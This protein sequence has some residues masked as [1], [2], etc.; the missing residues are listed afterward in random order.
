MFTGEPTASRDVVALRSMNT[1][2]PLFE[3]SISSKHL[4]LRVTRIL[5][6]ANLRVSTYGVRIRSKQPFMTYQQVGSLM[7]WMVFKAVR[8]VRPRSKDK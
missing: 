3:P 5:R 6:C 8:D 2:L 4:S 7:Y 1:P